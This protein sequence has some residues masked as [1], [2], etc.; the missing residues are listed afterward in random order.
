MSNVTDVFVIIGDSLEGFA[1]E[2]AARVAEEIRDHCHLHEMPPVI[3]LTR[4]DW[5]SLHGGR[6]QA[7]SSAIWFGWNYARPEELEEHLKAAGFTNI[8]MWSQ[9]EFAGRDGIPPR[10]VSW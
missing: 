8:T 2:T 1:Y 4:D 6:A 3:S 7:S 5:R 9:H 10:V